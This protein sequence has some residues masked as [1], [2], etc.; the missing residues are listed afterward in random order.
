MRASPLGVKQLA[1]EPL[2]VLRAALDG[3]VVSVV[4]AGAEACRPEAVG[5]AHALRRVLAHPVLADELLEPRERGLRGMDAGFRVLALLEPVV[6]ETE[7]RMT[8]GRVSPCPTSVARITEKVRKRIRSRPGKA[9]RRPSRAGARGRLPARP[10]HASRP[11]RGRRRRASSTSVRDPLRRVEHREHPRE[12]ESDHG[13]ADECCVADETR[14][15]HVA[16]RVD[17]DRELE[18]DEHEQERIQQVLDDLPHG[19]ALEAHLGRR[20]LGRVPAEEDPGRH[21]G[22]HG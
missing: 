13:E 18:A 11:R 8:N 15:G 1:A 21:G 9:R 3:S 19:D 20:Q 2:V 17:D 4:E 7:H 22:E 14:C 6:L 12:A 16:E 10:R 5:A